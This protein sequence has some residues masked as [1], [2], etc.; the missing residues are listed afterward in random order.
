MQAHLRCVHL[1]HYDKEARISIPS[2]VGNM[3]VWVCVG[4]AREGVASRK[5]YVETKLTPGTIMLKRNENPQAFY[6]MNQDFVHTQ[7]KE[8]TRNFENH[9]EP[10]VRARCSEI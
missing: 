7:R 2:S 6:M 10:A 8:E 5:D 9:E 4:V 3:V 1:R